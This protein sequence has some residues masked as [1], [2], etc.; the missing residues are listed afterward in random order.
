[1]VSHKNHDDDEQDDDRRDEIESHQEERDDENCE[2]GDS[3]LLQ[4]VGPHRQVLL[5]EDVEHRV[6]EDLHRLG[7]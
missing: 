7:K 4:G 1:M 2:Q 6:W 3:Q 5:V